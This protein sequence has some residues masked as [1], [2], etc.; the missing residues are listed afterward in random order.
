VLA[1]MSTDD[2]ELEALLRRALHEH[3][4]K[5]VPVGDGLSKIQ[6]RAADRRRRLVWLRPSIAVA[7]AAIA[8]VAAI[9]IP[10]AIHR[11]DNGNSGTQA[12][13][14]PTTSSIN[15]TTS[16]RPTE[17]PK[18]KTQAAK[19][20]A[21]VA[22]SWPYSSQ[23]VAARSGDGSLTN[24]EQ[25]ATTFVA[26]FT[27]TDTG[28]SLVAQQYGTAGTKVAFKVRS[29]GVLVSTVDLA[30]IPSTTKPSYVVTAANGTNVRLSKAGLSRTSDSITVSG[31]FA[32]DNHAASIWAGAGTPY[33]KSKATPITA[34]T[35]TVGS[36][37]KLTINPP[38]GNVPAGP[39]I[40]AAW[41]VDGNGQLLDFTAIAAN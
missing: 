2:R 26:S 13:S 17:T 6:R 31:T 3:A 18:Q 25:L 14:R 35:D 40:L 1:I 28:K 19:Q 10:T 34:A 37:W 39:K 5:V 29:N 9:A 33:D 24:P 11:M 22:M 16:A 8:A 12:G 32:P 30:K 4:Q 20:L 15:G 7:A 38:T 36:P 23:K 21:A 27:G 41:T